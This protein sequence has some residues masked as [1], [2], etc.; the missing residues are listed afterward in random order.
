V[1]A[2]SRYH[3]LRAIVLDAATEPDLTV[4]E[5]AGA[6]LPR[7]EAGRRVVE[8]TS[9]SL[10]LASHGFRER[11]RLPVM[12]RDPQPFSE[13]GGRRRDALTVAE[14]V[15]DPEHLATA[16]RIMFAVFPPARVEPTM[17]GLIQPPRVLGIDGWCVWLTHRSG[18]PAGAAYTF[19]DG[20]SVG[21]YQVTTLSEHRGHGVARATMA[22]ILDRYGDVPM[23]LTATGQGRPLYEQLGFR[24]IE[25]AIW[26]VPERTPDPTG[27]D[28]G[29]RLR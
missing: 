5:V 18:V 19:H 2:P 17:R 24:V 22:A 23:T 20:T 4:R 28:T 25:T 13:N 10:D 15:S 11:F 26:W 14:A 7:T 1:I 21:V 9:G 6:M 3:T 8:D 27:D 12:V 16:E 29:G